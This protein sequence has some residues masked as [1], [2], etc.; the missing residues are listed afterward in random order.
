MLNAYET[1]V[2]KIYL[3][4]TCIVIITSI[5]SI[6]IIYIPCITNAYLVIEISPF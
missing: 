1:V 4:N 2:S 3:E 6:I 5:I